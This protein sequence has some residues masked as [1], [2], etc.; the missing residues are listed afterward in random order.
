MDRKQIAGIL[1]DLPLM[2]VVKIGKE[3]GIERMVNESEET[4]RTRVAYSV[5]AER[6]GDNIPPI[7]RQRMAE[8]EEQA[9]I[10]NMSP[11]V[12]CEDG[13]PSRRKITFDGTTIKPL[14][15]ENPKK[16]GSK[17]HLSMDIV[18]KNPNGIKY[19]D[20]ILQ[21]GR[22]ADLRWDEKHEYLEVIR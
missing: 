14:V 18:I 16:A 13:K 1:H 15:T 17:P 8:I 3:R 7:I 5:Q 22:E 19:E 11:V 4:F 2:G 21:G 12:V 6:F 20:Y 10:E 9:K